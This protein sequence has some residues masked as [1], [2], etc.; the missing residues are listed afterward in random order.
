MKNI[1]SAI[2]ISGLLLA[3]CAAEQNRPPDDAGSAPQPA[4][5]SQQPAS[6]AVPALQQEQLDRRDRVSIRSLKELPERAYIVDSSASDLMESDAAF[7]QLAVPL[8]RDISADLLAYDIQDRAALKQ[9]L[10]VEMNIAVLRGDYDRARSII[11]RIRE[12]ETEEADRLMT[13]QVMGSLIDAWEVAGPANEASADLFERN[14]RQRL[15]RMQWDVVGDE[16][17]ARRKNA[18]QMNEAIFRGIIVSG[19]DPMLQES[20]GEI[21][22]EVARQ[23]VTFKS[24]L[25][26]QLPLQ[27]RINRVYTQL[28]ERN[29]VE[30]GD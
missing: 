13:G 8:S 25:V 18:E 10:G 3:S 29:G 4:V 1:A 19:L 2:V 16:V 24:I 22:Y 15:Q 26:L 9:L 28:A 7:D 17:L 14:L 5:S 12:L 23:L 30:L 21:D 6:E 11:G 27:E 20:G